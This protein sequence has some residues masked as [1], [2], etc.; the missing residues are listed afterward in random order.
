MGWSFRSAIAAILWV[1][2]GLLIFFFVFSGWW[3]LFP[4]AFAGGGGDG[5]LVLIVAIIALGTAAH[6]IGR[7]WTT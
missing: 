3:I 6:F 1:A 7:R 2:T 4:F 5:F